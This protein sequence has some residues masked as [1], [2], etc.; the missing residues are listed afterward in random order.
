MVRAVWFGRF[1]AGKL[2]AGVTFVDTAK[3][4]MAVIISLDSGFEF[5][6][7]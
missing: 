5:C 6:V 4:S 1:I 2:T 3:T 7:I